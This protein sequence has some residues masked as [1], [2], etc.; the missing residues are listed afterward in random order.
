MR[1]SGAGSAIWTLPLVHMRSF[2]ATAEYKGPKTPKKWVEVKK[3]KKRARKLL[4][5]KDRGARPLIMPP[6]INPK[7]L[8]SAMG[9]R[10]IDV[11]KLMIRLGE[12]PWTC[13]QPINKDLVELICEELYFEPVWQKTTSDVDVMP[14]KKPA[15]L[16][17]FPRRPLVVTIMGHV[18]H[19][20][21]T[22]LDT[23]RGTNVAAGEAGGIT[24]RVSIFQAKLKSSGEI[25]TFMDTPGH[26]AFASIRERGTNVTDV[27]CLVVAA[28]DGPQE[29]T[30]EAIEY[31]KKRKVPFFVVITKVDKQGS[32]PEAVYMELLKH[33]IQLEK[34]GGDVASVEVS[35]KTGQGMNELEDAIMMQQE[36]LDPRADRESK[37]SEAVVIEC[38]TNRFTGVTTTTLVQ[39]GCLRVGDSFVAG[40]AHG[41][42][43]SLTT[44]AGQ[45]L[46]EA[47]P[48]TPVIV[49]G[50]RDDPPSP[51][52]LMITVSDEKLARKIS[53]NRIFMASKKNGENDAEEEDE[54]EEEDDDEDGSKRNGERDEKALNIIIKADLEGSL[55]AIEHAFLAL[56]QKEV[57]LRFVRTGV[58]EVSPADVELA[59]DS[60]AMMVAFNVSV[61][62]RVQ[63]LAE[64]LEVE[65]VESDIIYRVLEASKS[66]IEDL[67]EPVP[68]TTVTGEAEVLQC[69]PIQIAGESFVVGGSRVRSGKVKGSDTVRVMRN[70]QKLFEG[71]LADLKREKTVAKEVHKN[72]ECGIRLEG[73]NDFKPGDKIEALDIKMEKRKLF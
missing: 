40:K 16:K 1:F 11:L 34:Y 15:D 28:D 53:E 46:K 18:D 41:R 36:L 17:A 42:I 7:S 38:E 55:E 22:L 5:R 31:I 12:R 39:W 67:L 37:Q 47:L 44:P 20:K 24:Q 71:S 32:N 65:L 54:D 70:G 56:P 49:V 61:P 59:S 29:Q 57:K 63:K 68:V 69:F 60:G 35:A 2:S 72:M 62:S 52:D 21:T 45:Q 64:T 19:G 27:A 66:R 10:T 14:I 3:A 8:S 30:I 9:I 58:G 50:C 43:K 26:A 33:E 51:G 73:F 23:L 13:E 4:D 25:V 48:S 6:D